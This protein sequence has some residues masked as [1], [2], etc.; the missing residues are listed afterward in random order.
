MKK[1]RIQKRNLK[2]VGIKIKERKLSV[3]KIKQTESN[4]HE[5]MNTPHF[6]CCG[7]KP[8][9]FSMRGLI[10]EECALP[11]MAYNQQQL[12]YSVINFDLK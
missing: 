5:S 2:Y 7:G 4:I 12:T 11:A 3:I 10:R 9:G 6:C 1:K 8:K